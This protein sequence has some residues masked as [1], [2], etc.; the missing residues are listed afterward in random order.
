MIGSAQCFSVQVKSRSGFPITPSFGGIDPLKYDVGNFHF[1]GE[2]G[3]QQIR[4]FVITVIGKPQIHGLGEK[5]PRHPL[6][7]PEQQ[8]PQPGFP[9]DPAAAKGA[10]RHELMPLPCQEVEYPG[11]GDQIAGWM[12]MPKRFEWCIKKNPQRAWS[13]GH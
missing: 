6:S 12:G 2:G 13:M 10:C 5:L 11:G 7:F 1:S 8:G 4:G 3:S 9:V